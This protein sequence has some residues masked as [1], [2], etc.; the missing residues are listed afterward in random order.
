MAFAIFVC[1]LAIQTAAIRIAFSM[2]RDHCLPFG[3]RLAHV[4]DHRQSPVLPALVSGAIAILILILNL[5]NSKIFLVVTSVSIVLVYL[6][7][8]SVTVPV[9]ARRRRGWPEDGGRTGLFTL[10]RTRG[11]IINS[12]AVGYGALMAINL[13]FPRQAIYGAGN[14]AW[15]GV[16]VIALVLAVGLAYFFSTQRDRPLEIAAEHRA[17]PVP[18]GDGVVPPPRAS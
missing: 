18:V 16:I 14:Y 11:M 9:L 1:T 8:L 2:A 6:A 12:I 3:E 5:G 13:I 10:G 7:Y 17:E 4:S 15:G